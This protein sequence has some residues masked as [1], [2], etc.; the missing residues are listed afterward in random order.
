MILVAFILFLIE[1]IGINGQEGGML[2]GAHLY[3]RKEY[4][5]GAFIHTAGWGITASYAKRLTGF[6]KLVFSTDFFNLK[7]PKEAKV[8]QTL[9]PGGRPYVFGKE[10]TTSVWT[11]ESGFKKVL[12]VKDRA[13]GV[14]ISFAGMGGMALFLRKPVYVVVAYP[15][16]INPDRITV[17]KYNVDKHTPLMIKEGAPF[18]YGL[19]EIRVIYGASFKTFIEMDMAVNPSR[20]FTLN[21][22]IIMQVSSRKIELLRYNGETRFFLNLFVGLTFGWKKYYD[23]DSK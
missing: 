6:T 22:G 13:K 21:G 17:E 19:D 11:L 4:Q 14:Q 16:V 9:M 23:S 5:L 10:F 2:T 8:E 18:I 1:V 12:Y 15:N 3:F 20:I 7:H